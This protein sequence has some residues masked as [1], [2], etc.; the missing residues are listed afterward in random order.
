MPTL[1]VDVDDLLAHVQRR[2]RM[3]GIFRVVHELCA[4]LHRDGARFVR[5]AP[6]DALFIEIDWPPVVR[7]IAAVEAAHRSP[8]GT[9]RSMPS[10]LQTPARA[11]FR[12][13]PP[14]VAVALGVSLQGLKA[15]AFGLAGLPAAWRQSRAT[16]AA[17]AL[18]E[19]PFRPGPDDVI[20]S[21]GA[22]WVDR[23]H[24]LR[25]AT[26]RSRGL[27]YALL[28]HDIIP[29]R[30]PEW[31]SLGHTLNF[32]QW[33]TAVAPQADHLLTISHATA[34]DVMTH[35]ARTG[36][37]IVTPQVVPMG[38]GFT[39]P[40]L[41]EPSTRLPKPGS[42]VLF[43]STLE[44]RKNH[45][46]AVRIWR[47][48]L[49]EMPT[50][51]VP[52]LVFVGRPGPQTLDLMGQLSNSNYLDGAI[53]HLD[54]AS[55]SELRQLYEGCRF[56]LFPSLYEGW[57][58]PVTESLAF[59]R[60]C[61]AARAT[62]LPEAGGTFARY[63]DP[64]NLHDA[65]AV[66]RAALEDEAGMEEMAAQIRADFRAATWDDMATAARQVCTAAPVTRQPAPPVVTE[67]RV[68]A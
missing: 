33:F 58:L 13:L 47:R 20:F 55:D 43:V 3:T 39:L 30:R 65:V 19:R 41:G 32:A 56:T 44:G 23:L 4:A 45:I 35:A 68:L 40:P 6:G 48:L 60:P 28:V 5:H 50:G 16:A 9:G 52:Q 18:H 59:G 26:A 54:D 37:D 61:L 22:P 1:W 62:S 64:D 15:F 14:V 17:M 25:V 46:L 53:L 42:Y 10:W 21:P 31:C 27:R 11:L 29:L 2:E 38:T 67:V 63:F 66:V 49:E 36:M 57:G 7:A 12:H 8:A 24:A 51:S 34:E